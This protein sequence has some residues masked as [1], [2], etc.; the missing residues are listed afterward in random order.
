[1]KIEGKTMLHPFKL[2]PTYRDYVWGG[3]R[4]RPQAEITAEAWVV[5]EE[6][7]VADGPYAGKTLA[8]VVELEGA[9]LL[10]S[11]PM[12]LTGKRFPLL[13]KLL[14]CARWLSLQV[15]PNDEQARRLAGPGFYGKTEAWYVVEADP[16]AQL[17]SGFRPGV[18]R[19]AIQAAV[20]KKSILDI[21][22]SRNVKAGDT[23]FIPP[24]TM[25]ALGPGLLIYEVQQSSDLTYRVYDWDRPVTGTRKLHI[26][27]SMEVLDPDCAGNILPTDP[28]PA[29]GRQKLISCKYFSLELIGGDRAGSVPVDLQGVSFSAVTA[30][31]GPIKVHAGEWFCELAAL[32]TLLIPAICGNY[33]VTFDDQARALLAHTVAE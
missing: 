2:N 8:E 32:E 33:Q 26:Q 20:G 16:G 28:N 1:L 23:I 25:H 27:E 17:I 4:L 21:V 31:N 7:Q 13:I 18:T 19:Q 14:D 6:D 10:G 9:A 24:G 15:H 29:N 11:Q 22:E 12:A 5:F 30:L 3:K